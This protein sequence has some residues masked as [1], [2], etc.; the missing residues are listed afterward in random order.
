MT[1]QDWM[2]LCAYVDGELTLDEIKRFEARVA[3]SPE[4][5]AELASMQQYK[6]AMKALR[7]APLPEA[8][9][10]A[11][12]DNGVHAD[13]GLGFIAPIAAALCVAV[14]AL[15]GVLTFSQKSH[16]LST[17]ALHD[18]LSKEE[19]VLQQGGTPTATAVSAGF[20]SVPD[21]TPARLTLVDVVFPRGEAYGQVALHYRGERGCRL[22]LIA[23]TNEEP[24][25]Q[26]DYMIRQW[27]TNDIH[28]T[29]V[30]KGMDGL[31]F[32]A[33]ADFA[34]VQS[35]LLGGTDPYRVAM[36]QRTNAGGP[37]A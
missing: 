6:T 3:N 5:Q 37:C 17:I 31:R 9:A 21:L 24:L 32:A 27:T 10:S 13:S 1:E 29:L 8:E 28:F 23:Q 33:I 11:D 2:E 16:P 26:R 20:L 36:K 12:N 34:L 4:L 30:S 19:Y 15:Y 18:S 22:T 7:P 35:R 25:E 14:I